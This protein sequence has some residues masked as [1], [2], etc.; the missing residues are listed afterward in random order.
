MGYAERSYSYRPGRGGPSGGQ[1][2]GGGMGLGGGTGAMTPWVKRL[3]I[4]NGA[5]FLLMAVGLLPARW[6]VET[7]GF[8]P[9]DVVRHP[10]SPITYMFLHGGFWHLFV[11]MLVLFFFG[12][13]LERRWGSTAFLR[14]Y[15]AAGLGG[16]LFSVLLLPLPIIQAEMLVIGA[17]GAVFGLMLAFALLWPEARIYIWGIFPMRA[18]WFVGLLAL[19]TVYATFAGGGGNVAHWAHLGGLVTGFVYL[20]F[21]DRIGSALDRLGDRLPIGG[22]GG[23]TVIRDVSEGGRAR[24]DARER[25]R[26]SRDTSRRSGD[27]DDAL[28]EVDRILDKIRDRGLDSLT[29]EER[30]FLDEMSRRY[31][32]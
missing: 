29:P 13:P 31:R 6:A 15:L 27:E 23:E 18:K 2:P 11:N 26:T 21:W 3:L 8:S 25:E 4:A 32:G 24:R 5:I 16:A 7:F 22:G 30:E 14:Y 12:P 20:R 9:A 1:G 19:F 28:D 10:W 17:S